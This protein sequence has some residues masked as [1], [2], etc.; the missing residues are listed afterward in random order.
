MEKDIKNSDRFTGE[1][2]LESNKLEEIFSLKTMLRMLYQSGVI[3]L[4]NFEN[5]VTIPKSK[6]SS[7]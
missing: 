7:T 1:R 3:I 5:V 6:F 4:R 2:K